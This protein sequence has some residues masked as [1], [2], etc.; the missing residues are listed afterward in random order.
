M[1]PTPARMIYYRPGA[2]DEAMKVIDGEPL[3][4]IVCGVLPNG[5]V[6]LAV[7]DASG[8]LHRRTDVQLVQEGDVF[9]VGKA[10]CHWMPYQLAVARGDVAPPVHVALLGGGLIP[11]G[12]IYNGDPMRNDTGDVGATIIT[13]PGGPFSLAEQ[14]KPV[15]VDDSSAG[16]AGST[17]S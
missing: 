1:K 7:F 6:N 5:R 8:M 16:S 15:Q 14:G 9:E 11:G 2:G 3:A 4:A 12:G 10:H 13:A 17:F